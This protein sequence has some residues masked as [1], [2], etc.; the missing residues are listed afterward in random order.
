VQGLP[1]IEWA[2]YYCLVKGRGIGAVEGQRDQRTTVSSI[3][4]DRTGE[5]DIYETELTL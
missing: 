1:G 5:I 4:L 3:I 2:I